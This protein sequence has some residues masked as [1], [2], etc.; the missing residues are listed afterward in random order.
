MI[1]KIG[2]RK[3]F[4]KISTESL[5]VRGEKSEYSFEIGRDKSKNESPITSLFRMVLHCGHQ[6]RD[7]NKTPEYQVWMNTCL[8]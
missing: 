7:Y 4:S 6:S 5:V 1:S 8:S 2:E 3:E